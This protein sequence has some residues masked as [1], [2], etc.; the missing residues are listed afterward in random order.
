MAPQTVDPKSVAG[1]TLPIEERPDV[2]VV[3]AGPAGLA[4]ALAAARR[5]AAVMLVDEN[6]VAFAT[7]G[8]DVP[9]HFGQTMS[10]AARGR[11]AMFDAFVVSEPRIAEAYEAGVDLRLGVACWGLYANG[12]ALGWM[13][14]LVAGLADET[15][16]WLAQPRHVVLACGRRDM[17]LAFPGWDKPGVVGATAALRL[18][19]RYAAFAPRRVVVQGTTTEALAAALALRAQ[20]VEIVALVEQATQPVGDAATLAA[21][22]D[23]GTELLLAHV[24]REALGR[25][26]V[27]AALVAPVDAQGRPVGAE[28]RIA[29]D[30]VVQ[31]VAATPAIELL[32]AA[33]GAVAFQSERGGH[34]PR[35]DAAGGA[36]LPGVYVVGDGAGVWDAKTL[37]R[38]IAE[39]EGERAAAAIFGE[40]APPPAPP[41]A[42]LY[43]LGGYRVAWARASVIHAGASVHV[44]QCEQ[45]TARELLEL[46]P[47]RYLDAPLDRR[48]DR[49]LETLLGAGPPHPDQVK[50]LTR[51]GMGLCQGRRCREQIAALLALQAGTDLAAI[52]LAGHRAPTRPL[53]LSQ[54]AGLAEDAAMTQH[55][56]TWFGMAAQWR[57]FWEVPEHYTVADHD[58]ARPAASE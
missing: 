6:P 7:M 24:V 9:L 46:R 39:A 18:A 34:A 41:P 51:A 28:R 11:N 55:W 44:C 52:P 20:G 30:G 8:D 15:R 35:L 2:L 5:G 3:G 31:G 19:T 54:M 43:D 21:L 14:G 4:A 48:N 37:D 38:R 47:P 1:R 10:G 23:A 12:A 42:P 36:S 33:G 50:R 22:R 27:E 53:R 16:C 45:V 56:D 58:P 26:S 13:P 57:P 17:G 29:C 32:D 49:S 25:E 40:V